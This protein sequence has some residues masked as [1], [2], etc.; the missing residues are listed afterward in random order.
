M[1][2][3]GI[4]TKGRPATSSLTLLGHCVETIIVLALGRLVVEFI[5]SA[6]PFEAYVG[7]LVVFVVVVAVVFVRRR[8]ARLAQAY[9]QDI[10]TST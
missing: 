2:I 9:P 4:E 6:I 8:K 5:G 3:S 10:G 1:T 7:F